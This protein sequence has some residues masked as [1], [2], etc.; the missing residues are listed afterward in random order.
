M[1]FDIYYRVRKVNLAILLVSNC[2]VIAQLFNK[3]SV[4]IMNEHLKVVYGCIV[5]FQA[6]WLYIQLAAACVC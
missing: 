2:D 6:I 4:S 3:K 1:N 5:N